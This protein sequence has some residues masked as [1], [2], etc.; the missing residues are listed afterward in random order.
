MGGNTLK[1]PGRTTGRGGFTIPLG[2]ATLGRL[3][4]AT[5]AEEVTIHAD[6]GMD[7]LARGH[8]GRDV[9]HVRAM[10]G[11]VIIQFPILNQR[12]HLRGPAAR[13]NLNASLPWE[14]EFRNEARRVSA[15]LQALQLNSLD[16][17]GYASQIALALSKPVSTAYVYLAG[18]ADHV[19]ITRPQG[20]GVR[21]QFYDGATEVSFDGQHFKAI[22][23]EALLESKDYPHSASR[24]NI[25]LCGKINVLEVSPR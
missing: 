3:V 18:G 14:I 2:G 19:R 6:P 4:F 9:P 21:F 22:A 23:G 17:L 8:F 15:D 12:I 11:S 10:P 13:I 16:I 7:A 20:V 5:R 1:L 25:S 24:Y